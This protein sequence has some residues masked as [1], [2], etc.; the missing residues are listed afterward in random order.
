MTDNELLLSVD[1]ARKVVGHCT[2]GC[3]NAGIDLR[4]ML[5]ERSPDLS[6]GTL[7]GLIFWLGQIE[8]VR[9]ERARRRKA[10]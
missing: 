9:K 8:G 10:Q 2:L 3:V 4:N 7:I 6:E 1:E 5:V